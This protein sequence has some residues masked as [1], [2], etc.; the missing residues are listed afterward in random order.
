MKPL[1]LSPELLRIASRVVWFKEPEETLR[2][3]IHFLAHVMTYGS[4]EDL[5]EIDDIV[6]MED[7]R[8]TL[9]HAPPGVFDPRSWAYWNLICG[10]TPCPPLPLRKGVL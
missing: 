3:P 5:K 8:E 4:L 6:G 2:E 1:P 10:R 7:Y 9:D